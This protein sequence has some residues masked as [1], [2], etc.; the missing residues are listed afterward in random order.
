MSTSPNFCCVGCKSCKENPS[1]SRRVVKSISDI[2]CLSQDPARIMKIL[3]VTA[4]Q[5]HG[6]A[7]KGEGHLCPRIMRMC[8]PRDG[9]QSLEF[10]D[11]DAI[12]EATVNTCS[13][14]TFVVAMILYIDVIYSLKSDIS[15][16]PV[17]NSRLLS[18]FVHK[19]EGVLSK[20]LCKAA[21]RFVFGNIVG[22][23]EDGSLIMKRYTPQKLNDE[24]Q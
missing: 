10:P 13:A 20:E 22:F 17:K 12:T 1:V 14:Y 16:F 8:M 9:G 4:A 23:S 21:L 15:E 18:E 3:T 5:L 7:W 11:M 2:I 19:C 6:S 24:S